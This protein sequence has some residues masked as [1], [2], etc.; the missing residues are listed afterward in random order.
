MSFGTDGLI[1]KSIKQKLNTKSSTKAELVGASDYLPKIIWVKMFLALQGYQLGENYLEH[2]N[3][4]AIKLEKNGRMSAGPR[5][6]HI[7]IRYFWIKDRSR[8][9]NI[10]ITKHFLPSLYR[11]I[12]SSV[13]RM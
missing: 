2:D 1:C 8:Q 10:T 12:F 9:E 5:S 3:E 7:N 13:S 4:S 6:R 11:E